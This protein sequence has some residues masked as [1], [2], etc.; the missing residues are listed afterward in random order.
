MRRKLLLVSCVLAAAMGMA[1]FLSLRSGEPSYHGRTLTD[2][3][4]QYSSMKSSPE[5]DREAKAAVRAM[6]TGKVI[7][8]LLEMVAAE[9]GTVRSWLLQKREDWNIPYLNLRSADEINHWGLNGFIILGTNGAS[10]VPTLSKW[11]DESNRAVPAVSC[12]GAIGDPAEAP[13]C[14][15]LTNAD[16][17]VRGCAAKN[18][19][20]VTRDMNLYL[21]LMSNALADPV[22]GV[23]S[24]A[25]HALGQQTGDPEEVIPILTAVL[26]D[27]SEEVA[28]DAFQSLRLFG[29][30]ALKAF[31]AITNIIENGDQ[32]RVDMAMDLLTHIAPDRARPILLRHSR[33]GDRLRT[34]A[35]DHMR[36]YDPAAPEIMAA[37]LEARK[38]KDRQVQD[39]ATSSLMELSRRKHGRRKVTFE[40]EPVYHG[41]S[42]SEWLSYTNESEVPEDTKKAV[43]AM[44]TNAIPALLAR[45]E[46]RD[47]E[48]DLDDDEENIKAI[49]GFYALGETAAPALP[50]L[51]QLIN[52]DHRNIALFA[53]I[54]ATFVGTNAMPVLSRALTNQDENVRCWLVSF[55]GDDRSQKFGDLRKSVVPILFGMLDDQSQYVRADVTNT[56]V[57]IDPK[58]AAKAGLK[59]NTS[60]VP[61]Q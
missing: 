6:N 32:I 11:L 37:L 52:G 9:D 48:F 49:A 34:F 58:A 44:G 8:R 33:P 56:L 42:L 29:T 20:C 27:P 3:L 7:P 24:S 53:S 19:A 31:S 41:R 46:Y 30:N 21:R 43:Q 35:L 60:A 22:A 45:L 54:C 36:A 10:A 39:A 16:P 18:L 57:E 15:A 2:W 51:D 28:I 61:V 59:R 50:R 25:V 26:E 5:Q 12:L 38:D 55:F 1:L 13:V 40:S 47:P 4:E 14:R 23:R 17:E